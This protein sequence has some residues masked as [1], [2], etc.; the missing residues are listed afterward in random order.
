MKKIISLFLSA[1]ILL[2]FSSCNNTKNGTS[3]LPGNV[4]VLIGKTSDNQ[5]LIELPDVDNKNNEAE[6]VFIK[7]FIQC[8]LELFTG[9]KLDLYYAYKEKD[10]VVS[11]YSNYCINIKSYVTFSSD[12]FVSIV[13][14]GLLNQKN[15]AHPIRLFFTVNYN[16]QTLKNVPFSDKYNI[17]ES[18]YPL[19][20]KKTKEKIK[21]QYGLNYED[22]YATLLA[23]C[24]EKESLLQNIIEGDYY[25]YFTGETIGIS[26]P[27]IF[28]L[29]DHIEIEIPYKT[30]DNNA[31]QFRNS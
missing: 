16:P 6:M 22:V 4:N 30:G 17:D 5:I 27:V 23:Q 14:D 26:I 12:D 9:E 11:D 28:A 13:F 2:L 18:F 15:T 29:G 10:N 1:F 8:E 31:T 19:F 24:L 3:S 25:Y 21:S 7:D 20:L